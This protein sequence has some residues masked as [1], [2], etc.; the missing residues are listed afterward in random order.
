MSLD[1]AIKYGK[2][3]RKPY[4]GAKLIDYTCRNHGACP[5]CTGNRTYSHKKA[6]LISREKS[7][8]WYEEMYGKLYSPF[9]TSAEFLLDE[10]GKKETPDNT[11][12]Y[13]GDWS[14]LA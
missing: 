13:G 1:K 7:V 12:L 4:R 3:H 10:K 5:W 8:A 11:Y 2:E 6:D 14:G 9:E